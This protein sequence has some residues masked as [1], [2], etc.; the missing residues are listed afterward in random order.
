[1]R[2]FAFVAVAACCL[3]A[4]AIAQDAPSSPA[5]PT[6]EDIGHRNSLTLGVGGAITPDY[7]GSNDYRVIPAAAI[8]GQYNGIAFSTRGTY[9]YVDLIPRGSGKL[10]IDAGPIAGVR[11]GTRRHIKDDIVEL[12]PRR[13]RAIE[14]GGFAGV[15]FHGVTNPYDTL[16][17]HVDVTHDIGDAHKSTI[18]APNAEFSTPLSRTLYAS[19]NVGMEFVSNRFADYYFS[20]SPSDS[21]AT[22]GVLPVYNAGGGLKNWKAGVLLN[23]SLSGDLLHGFSLFGLGQYSRLVGDFKDSPI[24]RQRGSANQWLGAVGVAYSW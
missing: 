15:S 5:L 20:I 18:I 12:L 1:M 6:P 10:D 23:Q 14:V 9:L 7:E 2:R 24:V 22:G 8:R 19:A 3:S 13:K 16:G 4:P 11:L 21:V 17:F